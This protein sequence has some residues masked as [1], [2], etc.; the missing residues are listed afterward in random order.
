MDMFTWLFVGAV[1][2]TGCY[3]L[4]D[5]V[6]RKMFGTGFELQVQ[7]FE[8][9]SDEEL[10]KMTKAQLEEYGREFGVELDKRK[11]K[12]NMVEQLKSAINGE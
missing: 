12:A 6:I 7:Q 10:M 2:V 3:L 9:P 5:F 11:T 1:F 4:S 8:L